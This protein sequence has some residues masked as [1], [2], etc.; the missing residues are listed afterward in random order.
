MAAE[1]TR[2]LYLAL[3]QGG[4]ASRALVFDA[5][6]VAQARSLR[7]VQVHHPQADWVEQDPDDLVA[8]L[9]DA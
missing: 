3:D 6:G 7:E 8:S 1:Q 9:L 4:H 2:P 5:H